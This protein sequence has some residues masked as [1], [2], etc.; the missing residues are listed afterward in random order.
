M[1]FLIIIFAIGVT[2]KQIQT[3]DYHHDK[4]FSHPGIYRMK[5][6]LRDNLSQLAQLVQL[7]N[8]GLSTDQQ[9]KLVLD[10]YLV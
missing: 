7:Q 8:R 1:K 3:E 10:N 6:F 5:D 4:H 2:C 9:L